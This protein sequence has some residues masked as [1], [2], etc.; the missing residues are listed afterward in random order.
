MSGPSLERRDAHHAIH[1]AAFDEAE[2]LTRLLRQA[3]LARAPEHA[4]PLVGAL[5]EHWQA[6]TLQHAEAEEAGWYREVVA[7]RP[8]RQV[9][10]IAL[11]R[12]HELLRILHAEIQGILARHGTLAGV[13]ERFEAMLLVNA[14]HSREEE[15]RLL[16]DTD[17]QDVQREPGTAPPAPPDAADA[18]A[19][20]IPLA[21]ARP[22]LYA[23][24][25]TSLD[26]AG[27]HPGDLAAE[28]VRGPDGPALRVRS[29]PAF[30]RTRE[31]PLPED[32]TGV[33]ALLDE[34]AAF[35]AAAAEEAYRRLMQPP[36]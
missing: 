15:R 17:R 30:A 31:W 34:A 12:D 8:D 23:R 10:V 3:I 32:E 24:L 22:A 21:V 25:L 2:Q 6:R 27:A 16:G 20:P 19:G 28:V 26:A 36:P 35:C 14:I 4:A 9:D 5:I 1:Q 11:T 7:A 29:G 18:P 33:A 13:L